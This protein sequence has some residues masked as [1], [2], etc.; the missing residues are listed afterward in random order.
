MR[1][2]WILLISL[3]SLVLWSCGGSAAAD[4][5]SS[6]LAPLSPQETPTEEPATDLP[7]NPIQLASTA[8]TTDMTSNPISVDKFVKIAKQD[9]ADIL[10]IG[11]DQI[12]LIEA[13]EIRW[14]DAALGCPSPGKVYAQG[15]VPG[16]RVRLEVTGVEY[17]YHMDQTGQYVLCP[18][19]NPD[20]DI[21]SG[22]VT[23]G[24]TQSVDPGVPI[25]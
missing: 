13:V 19:L 6:E 18:E 21:L 22:S 4:E 1:I 20:K 14:P 11:A 10:K 2:R 25:K 8:E 12:S 16:Y 17:D 24:Q 5:Q 3:L 9:L 23:P 15:R 7:K